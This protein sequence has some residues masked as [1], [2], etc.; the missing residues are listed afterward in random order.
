MARM[1]SKH[2]VV[3]DHDTQGVAIALLQS[4]WGHLWPRDET[5]NWPVNV[6]IKG[7]CE[8][9]L[10]PSYVA[11]KLKESGLDTLGLVIDADQS[12]NNRWNAISQICNKNGFGHFTSEDVKDG[13]IIEAAGKKLGVWIMPN[14]ES[15]G[16]VE[17]F[18]QELVPPSQK[19]LWDFARSCTDKAKKELKAPFIDAHDTK[20]HIHTW[21]AWQ[22]TPGERMGLAITK[23]ILDPN[24]TSAQRFFEW[25]QKLFEL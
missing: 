10:D 8:A 5:G 16:M 21:L 7:S 9:I 24:A 14:N 3:E 4:K 13:L 22:N 25:C 20:A 1:Y 15:N 18:C 12:A 11:A 19:K 23:K 2:L 17:D 6:T